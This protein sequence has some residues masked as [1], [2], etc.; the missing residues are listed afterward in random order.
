M[1]DQE[2]TEEAIKNGR[3]R[4]HATLGTIHGTEDKPNT[5]QKTT[6]D[7]Q[8]RHKKT[9]GEP[10]FSP[11]EIRSCFVNDTHMIT[12]MDKYGTSLVGLKYRLT[13]LYKNNLLKTY[14]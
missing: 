13:A 3:S 10:M 9:L 4:A 7:A 2:K 8:G 1:D 6:D 5:N 11:R 12:H 14:F